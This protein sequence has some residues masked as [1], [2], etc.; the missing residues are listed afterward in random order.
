M[1][2]YQVKVNV[3]FKEGILDPQAE[4]ICSALKKLE[5]QTLQ[6]VDCQK[7]F[8]LTVEAETDE[9]AR[10]LGEEMAKKLLVNAVMEDYELEVL[11]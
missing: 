1:K 2:T 6:T 5:F 10:T 8:V 7:S 9:H 11:S 3:R 4:A